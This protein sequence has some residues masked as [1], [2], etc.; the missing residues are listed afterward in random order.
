[1]FRWIAR[2]YHDFI[3][4]LLIILTGRAQPKAFRLVRGRILIQDAREP[5]QI[6]KIPKGYKL[7]AIMGIMV[8]PSGDRL[9]ANGQL[10]DIL[11]SIRPNEEQFPII[12]MSVVATHNIL[13]T[14]KG[15][16]LGDAFALDVWKF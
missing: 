9:M 7:V 3:V 6:A 10:S 1:M 2:K 8:V 16:E 4:A 14:T 5:E 12:S 11:G 13:D 15:S